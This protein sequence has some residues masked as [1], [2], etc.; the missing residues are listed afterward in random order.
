MSVTL[1][2]KGQVLQVKLP[3]AMYEKMYR[4]E[5]DEIRREGGTR[6][7]FY[8]VPFPTWVMEQWFPHPMYSV[9]RGPFDGIIVAWGS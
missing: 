6:A 1:K 3:I 2:S 7:L 4:D 5:V 8:D 9:Q